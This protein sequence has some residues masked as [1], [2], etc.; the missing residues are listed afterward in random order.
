MTW[1]PRA[2][3]LGYYLQCDYRAALDKLASQGVLTIPPY[4][5][6]P[7]ADLGT[8]IHWV[9]Q[10]SMNCT[11]PTG[12]PGPPSPE[13]HQNAATL[14]K[15]ALDFGSAVQRAAALAKAN[16]PRP[17]IHWFAEPTL[18]YGKQLTGHADFISDDGAD[19]VDLKTTSRKPDHNRMKAEH[20]VQMCAYK[21][22]KPEL[23]WGHVLYVDSMSAQWAMVVTI[24]FDSP[25]VKEFLAQ[26]V[27]YLAYLNSKRLDKQCVPHLGA[28]CSS[29]F[30]PYI[31]MC[32]DK[33]I[34]AP[35]I[36][37]ENLAPL[38]QTTS[39]FGVLP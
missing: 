19:L 37:Q 17:G 1:K 39:P 30:C 13:T 12:H 9:L 32:K 27:G 18:K 38:P 21:L 23:Q 8:V 15:S 36:P 29:G 26:L 28:H 7:Y 11:F 4:V 10:N 24:D 14:F 20:F 22:M 34:P 5:P 6:A 16:M 25:E 35:G 31:N 3:S 33:L 2:S